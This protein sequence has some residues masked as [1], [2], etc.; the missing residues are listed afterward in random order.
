MGSQRGGPR[1]PTE[2]QVTIAM[3]SAPA[4]LIDAGDVTGLA[5]FVV[6]ILGLAQ[7]VPISLIVTIVRR[8][9]ADERKRR[10]R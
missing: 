3:R 1:P 2:A 9:L 8:L 7:G 5:H 6:D 4:S 10:R